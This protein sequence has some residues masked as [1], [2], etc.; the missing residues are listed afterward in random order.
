MVIGVLD[1]IRSKQFWVFQLL[2]WSTWVLMSVLR[3]IIVVPPEYLFPRALVSGASAI[4]AMFLTAGLRYLY[5]LVW[6]RGFVVRFLVGWFGSFGVAVVWQP[7]RNYISYI[8]FGEM[9]SLSD[10]SAAVIFD[11]LF[12]SSFPLILLWSG[13]YFIIKYYQLFQ[14]EKEKSLR[15]ESLAHEAQLLMLRYQLNPHFL[16]NTLN[17]ISTLVLSSANERAN[18]MLTKLSKFLRYSL[19]HSPLDKVSLAH[20]LETSKLYLD[21][22]K[23]RFA[24]R[25]RLDI[26]IERRAELAMVPT[27]LLQPLIE[28]SIKY[29]IS[30]SE[31]GGIIR[32][33]AQVRDATLVLQVAD[34]GP[35]VPELNGESDG[36]TFS[37]GVGISNIRNR[38]QE[39]YASEHKL[40][41]SNAESG[42]LTV[43]VEI[44]YDRR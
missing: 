4:P 3:D 18:E 40:I 17:A 14:A 9:L 25:L 20:E 30:K 33:S 43:T 27:M 23:V 1:L 39:I 21:I 35:G 34:D 13:L 32:I 16:F 22:E 7:I 2:G 11:N 31:T 42:G 15:S 6:E 38:L 37:Q 24:E 12:S 8:P 5:K 41:F 29:A 26:D 28:N 10:A 36:S 44:P 19:D